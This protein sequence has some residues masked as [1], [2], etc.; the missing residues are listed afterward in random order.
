MGVDL[1]RRYDILNARMH[2][3]LVT[4]VQKGKIPME[5]AER[6]DKFSPGKYVLHSLWGVGKVESW[7]IGKNEVV[8]DFE[9]QRHYPMGLKLAFNQLTPI[10]DDHFLI[11]CYDDRSGCWQKA[12]SEKTM[13]AYIRSVLEHNY[14]LREGV[15]EILP[16]SVADLE[17]FLR[18]RIVPDEEWKSWWDK[19]RTAMRNAPEFKLPMHRGEGIVL[20]EADSAAEALYSDYNEAES[21]ADCV[22]V[23]DVAKL[24]ILKGHADVAVRLA[25]AIEHDV[26]NGDDH[27]TQA[28]IELILVRDEIVAAVN[29]DAKEMVIDPSGMISLADKLRTISSEKMTSF[30][31]DIASSRQQKIYEALPKAFDTESQW[32]AYVVNIFLFGGPKAVGEAA[33]FIIEKGK[34]E[35]LFADIQNGVARQSLMPDVLV[36]ICRERRG[37]AKQV[38][39]KT[40]LLLGSAIINAIER[41]SAEGGP[42]KA[43]RLRNMLVEDKEL[44]PDLV[45]GVSET[46]A[47]PFAKSIYDS[48]SLHDLDRGLLLANMMKVHPSLQEIALARNKVQEKQPLYVSLESYEKVK[49]EYEDLINVRIPQNK[50][51]LAVTRAEGDLRENGGYQDAKATRQ[52]LMRRSE[53]LARNLAQ[54]QPTDFKGADTSVSGMGT[55]MTVVA[56]DGENITFTIL[57]AW[58]SDPEKHIV[59]YS[60]R[61]GKKLIGH[62]VGDSFR[63]PLQSG[64]APVKLTVLNIEAVNP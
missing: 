6:L 26:E 21:L 54:A 35:N 63:L 45:R 7:K 4:L 2:A 55:R 36:W 30:I 51:D 19:V 29:A 20:R 62:K 59:S 41:D 43:L 13:L 64:E 47:R 60:S 53:E 61:M 42:S 23:L 40:K 24:D 10:Q 27:D 32:L 33:R 38:F 8:I 48:A 18:G 9:I 34:Q 52:V 57:G 39:E 11:A 3:D 58:D 28:V 22:R 15:D 1:A 56:E 46:E 44:A 49:A 14:S 50:H 25:E 12:K 37:V 5:F 31:G 17:K 16:M